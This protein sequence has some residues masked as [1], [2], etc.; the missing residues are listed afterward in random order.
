MSGVVTISGQWADG[1]EFL[2]IPN[3]ARMNRVGPPHAYPREE[4]L[5]SGS[6]TTGIASPTNKYPKKPSVESK[7]WV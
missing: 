1:T 5:D 3:Y 4:D 7:V 6:S 2:A